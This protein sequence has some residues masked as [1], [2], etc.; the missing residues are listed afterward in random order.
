MISRRAAAGAYGS[1]EHFLADVT[2]MTR[3][4]RAFNRPD[5]E[6]VACAN[7]LEAFLRARISQ[8]LF[9]GAAPGAAAAGGAGAGAAS[10]SGR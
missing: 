2:L 10:S 6:Y 8:G 7:K 3:N 9:T 5:S 4:C 1:L